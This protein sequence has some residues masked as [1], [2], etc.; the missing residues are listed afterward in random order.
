MRITR[1]ITRAETATVAL[2][3]HDLHHI[4]SPLI[5]GGS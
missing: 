5:G 4:L 3:S 2:D 1:S